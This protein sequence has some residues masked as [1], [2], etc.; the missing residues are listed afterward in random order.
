M[1]LLD[2]LSTPTYA[3]VHQVEPSSWSYAPAAGDEVG[4]CDV[5]NGALR[6][7]DLRGGPPPYHTT[8]IAMKKHLQKVDS[9]QG[10]VSASRARAYARKRLWL[11]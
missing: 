7:V 10:K 3:N 11:K 1:L 6:Q 5:T 2:T 9:T 4:G 8:P